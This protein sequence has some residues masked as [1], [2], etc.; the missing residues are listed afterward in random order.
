[1]ERGAKSAEA[2]KAFQTHHDETETQGSGLEQI[3][4]MLASRPVASSARHSLHRR[5]KQGNHGR[6]RRQSRRWML[7]SSLPLRRW[8]IYEISRYGT[9]KTWAMQLGMK[10]AA[11]LLDDQTLQ[12]EMKTDKLLTQIAQGG[13]NAKAA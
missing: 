1:M 8:S 10:D 4:E 6:F 7:A 2:K 5:G 9:L 12:E 3:F 11:N 13:Q